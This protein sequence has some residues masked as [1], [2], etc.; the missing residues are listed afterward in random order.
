MSLI[1]SPLPLPC[2]CLVT[3]AARP[4][5]P[6]L[7]SSVCP[8][9]SLSES[10][11]AILDPSFCQGSPTCHDLQQPYSVVNLNSFPPIFRH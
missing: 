10:T 6:S 1:L 5:A 3:C 2:C 9:T 7:G 4:P 11:L 8:T